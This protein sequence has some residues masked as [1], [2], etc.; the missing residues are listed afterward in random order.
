MSTQPGSLPGRFNFSNTK[1]FFRLFAERTASAIG[2]S[3]A[4]FA[5]VA[6]ILVWGISGLFFHFSDFWQLLVNTLTNV[7]TF[8]IVFLIQNSQNR[9]TKAIHLKLDELI[10]AV[11]QARTHLVGLENLS[12]DD[13]ERLERQFQRIRQREIRKIGQGTPQ[14]SSPSAEESFKANTR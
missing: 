10:R 14:D 4:F 5:A 2:S 6:L 7:L 1:S 13:L 8:L 9:D 11:G 3:G 12:D